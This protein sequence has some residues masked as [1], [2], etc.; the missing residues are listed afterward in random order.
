[1]SSQTVALGPDD[2][3]RPHCPLQ[4]ATSFG[5]S[6][7]RLKLFLSLSLCQ[8]LQVHR[9]DVAKRTKPK[10]HADLAPNGRACEGRPP[11]GPAGSAV[12]TVHRVGRGNG[13]L[14]QDGQPAS[15][16]HS[17]TGR[18]PLQVVDATEP[19]VPVT[20]THRSDRAGHHQW[21]LAW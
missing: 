9:I 8:V 15:L 6:F 3:K 12:D 7:G 13:C 16:E 1:M 5:T 10:T 11:C 19:G 14:A 17:P 18:L 4:R 21:E 20:A 2:P